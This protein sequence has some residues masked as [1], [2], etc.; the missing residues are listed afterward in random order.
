MCALEITLLPH[1]DGRDEIR[2]G[3]V[4]RFDKKRWKSAAGRQ[5]VFRWR[6]YLG[7]RVPLATIAQILSD[8]C[9]P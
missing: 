3:P 2:Y 7:W 9:V 6:R 4:L 8:G 5:S 1:D